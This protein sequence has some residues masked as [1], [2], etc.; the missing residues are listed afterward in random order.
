MA[1]YSLDAAAVMGL[2]KQLGYDLP[3]Q[4]LMTNYSSTR[5]DDPRFHPLTH[6]RRFDRDGWEHGP[7]VKLFSQALLSDYYDSRRH[8][9][10]RIH[11]GVVGTVTLMSTRTMLVSMSSHPTHSEPR[12]PEN[13]QA[14]RFIS[15]FGTSATPLRSTTVKLR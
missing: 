13:W 8:H 11:L 4:A 6:R 9:C 10:R 14:I 1:F 12:L 7:V 2:L 15:W 5:P 3:Q